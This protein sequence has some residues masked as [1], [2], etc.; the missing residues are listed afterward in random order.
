MKDADGAV[1]RAIF[2]DQKS[3]PHYEIQGGLSSP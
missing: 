1:R 2:V 3:F